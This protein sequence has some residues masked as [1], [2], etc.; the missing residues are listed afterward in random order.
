MPIVASYNEDDIDQGM[1]PIA[2]ARTVADW[3]RI[4]GELYGK[5]AQAFLALLPARLDA[6]V[7]ALA[8]RVA[9]MAGL[10]QA[11]RM[12]AIAQAAHGQKAY[13]DLFARKHPYTPGVIIAD[14]DTATIGAYHSGDV[15]YWLDTLDA[16]N[17]RRPTRDWTA[18]DRDLSARMLGSLIALARTG[19]PDTPAMAW[20]AW[21]A[22]A[23]RKLVLGDAVTV[24]PL[25]GRRLQWLSD[26]PFAAARPRQVRPRD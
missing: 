21:D 26:H 2:K 4:A 12:C 25:D 10:E 18:Y 11:V 17:A 20:P 5:D 19:S 23:E 8:K 14:Q 15:P 16:Y 3:Q 13:L 9:S 7:P 22:R 1:N 6:E 24:Q